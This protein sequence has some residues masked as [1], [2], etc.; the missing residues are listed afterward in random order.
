M[1]TGKNGFPLTSAMPSSLKVTRE[2]VAAAGQVWIAA[3][4]RPT[5]RAIVFILTRNIIGVRPTSKLSVQYSVFSVQYSVFS[6]QYSVFS[7]QGS[8][9]EVQCSMFKVQRSSPFNTAG[10][11]S[12]PPSASLHTVPSVPPP[13]VFSASQAHQSAKPVCPTP[14]RPRRRCHPFHPHAPEIQVDTPH[15]AVVPS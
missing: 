10:A 8:V 1:P 5:V 15:H 13:S 12:P 11:P 14:A 2:P 3:A 7:V 4:K 9:F 6:V